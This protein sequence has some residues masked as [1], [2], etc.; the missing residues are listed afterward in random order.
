[1]IRLVFTVGREILSLEIRGEEIWYKDRKWEKQIRLIPKDTDFIL[2]IK[3][4]RNK[5][6]STLIDMFTLTKE[7]EVQYE[8]AKHCENALAEQCIL[9][10]KKKGGKLILRTEH[11]NP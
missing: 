5:L 10:V 9:D 8:K 2:K 3:M 4:S 1:M 6:P 11:G 7:E